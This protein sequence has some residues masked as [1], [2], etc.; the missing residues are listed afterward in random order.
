MFDDD[1]DTFQREHDVA[2]SE[3]VLAGDVQR[4]RI[5]GGL[6]F[7][8]AVW[9]ARMVWQDGVP[10]LPFYRGAVKI[11]NAAGAHI[12]PVVTEYTPDRVCHVQICGS[13]DYSGFGDDADAATASL[14]E[15][16]GQ[17]KQQ[18]RDKHGPVTEEDFMAMR[19]QWRQALPG[20][21]PTTEVTFIQGYK[22]DPQSYRD[23]F[24]K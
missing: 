6:I 16:M 18:L 9:N 23:W 11:A 24:L 15:E 19:A 13:F 3:E 5:V 20:W 17:V 21:H 22:H 8:E 1:A 10:M 4:V 14:R 12:I 7:P 2:G